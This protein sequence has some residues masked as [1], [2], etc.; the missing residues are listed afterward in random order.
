MAQRQME[1]RHMAPR[2]ALR[3]ILTPVSPRRLR[4]NHP[5]NA[6]SSVMTE[7]VGGNRSLSSAQLH[8]ATYLAVACPHSQRPHAGLLANMER[9][10]K[11]KDPQ[12]SEATES[13]DTKFLSS[14]NPLEPQP[15][16][17]LQK[18]PACGPDWRSRAE[19]RLKR[20]RISLEKEWSSKTWLNK[21]NVPER[22]FLLEADGFDI[23]PLQRSSI[24]SAQV[25][26]AVMSRIEERKELG[27]FP[28][29]A[30]S[31]RS[32]EQTHPT[33][34]IQP[35][36]ESVTCHVTLA[37]TE[38]EHLFDELEYRPR[39]SVDQKRKRGK[40]E[41]SN[42]DLIAVPRLCEDER[43]EGRLR[44]KIRVQTPK[45]VG[46]AIDE[47]SLVLFKK[48]VIRQIFAHT[49]S[50]SLVSHETP[51]V[52]INIHLALP[53]GEHKDLYDRFGPTLLRISSRG[54][55]IVMNEMKFLA[56]DRP[57]R[58]QCD[59]FS[60]SDPDFEEQRTLVHGFS[61]ITVTEA[62]DDRHP[63]VISGLRRR[64]HVRTTD[65]QCIIA[66]DTPSIEGLLKRLQVNDLLHTS[67]WVFDGLTVV[68]DSNITWSLSS[69]TQCLLAKIRQRLQADNCNEARNVH[70]IWV[71]VGEAGHV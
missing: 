45:E 53:Q 20:A 27:K 51:L 31:R 41:A 57:E 6:V 2:K 17:F 52:S 64:I 60:I 1:I 62:S 14:Q 49:Q 36:A 43:S 3:K 37:E 24:S 69:E 15:V 65:T 47:Q 21:T 30:D 11:L 42:N 50:P 12:A 46:S 58:T 10:R 23:T 28:N 63:R 56:D 33:G 26:E 35:P 7:P 32:Q 44:K 39:V 4:K 29:R 18:H 22:L 71:Y 13:E 67:E 66:G 55:E 59:D 19:A 5:S 61:E 70:V 68:P 40:E 9:K 25:T 54:Y 48:N 34:A 38:I 16:P 8:L